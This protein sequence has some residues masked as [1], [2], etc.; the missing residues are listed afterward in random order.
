MP[1]LKCVYIECED[2]KHFRKLEKFLN[3]NNYYHYDATYCDFYT[4]APY[5]CRTAAEVEA[6]LE[7]K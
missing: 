6:E 7:G 5:A 2:E 4:Q 3:Q 1:L